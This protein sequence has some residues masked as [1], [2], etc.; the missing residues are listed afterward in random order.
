MCGILGSIGLGNSK[1]LLSKQMLSHRGPDDYGELVWDGKASPELFRVTPRDVQAAQ[2]WFAHW[3]LSILDLSEAG[4][5]PMRTVDGRYFI[6]YN[7]EVYN[8][9]E[10]RQKLERQGCSFRSH[11]DTEVVLQAYAQWGPEAL[12]Y[13]VGM[14]AFAVLDTQTRRVFLARDFFGIKPLYYTFYRNALIFASE[15]KALL[16]LPGMQAVAHP[17]RVYDYLRY[18]LTDHEAETF[19]QGIYQLPP[20][21]Y[22]VVPVDSP[23]NVQIRRYW[24]VIPKEQTEISFE[25]AANQLRTLFL[26]SVQLHLRSDVPLGTALSG[27]IDS[28]SIVAAIRYLEP[29]AEIHT[30]SFVPHQDT[31]IS[32]ERWIDIAGNHVGAY[33]HKVRPRPEDLPR[34]LDD[35]IY[36]QDEPFGSTSIYAQ[37]R[38]FRLARKAGIKVML[39]GQGA[40]ELLAGYATYYVAKVLSLLRQRR[41]TELAKFLLRIREVPAARGVLYLFTRLS[42]ALLP[43]QWQALPRRILGEELLP[44]WMNKSWFVQ[45]EVR[46]HSVW[47]SEEETVLRAQ[48]LRDL[49]T[50]SLPHLL[51]YEDRNSMWHSIESRVPFLTPKLAQFLLSLPEDYILASDGT[52]KAVFRRAMEGITP[53]QILERRDKIGF[54]TPEREWL[55]ALRPWV[56]SVLTS[57]TAHRIPVLDLREAQ[58]H[59]QGMLQERRPFKWTF[60]RWLNLIRW[61]ERFEVKYE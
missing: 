47:H 7:G 48:L 20:A 49:Q 52:T 8:Y 33:M 31:G 58:N 6:V 21:H 25:D 44:R 30:F 39:D 35:L 40:D 61:S 14:F 51:R 37:Y 19:F 18:G 43:Q 1:P 23:E 32:E 54:A 57:E 2:V 55:L 60:W 41:Y 27:G 16:A 38:V 45:R 9:R 22:M 36:A 4:W 34:D 12:K 29:R 53:A 26:E 5:Q 10:L 28:S 50:T 3:R 13:F 11:T 59:W 24:E 15:I 17:Q 42:A 56:E 46:F